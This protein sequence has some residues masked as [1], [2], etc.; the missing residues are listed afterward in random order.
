MNFNLTKKLLKLSCLFLLNLAIISCNNNDYNKLED[1][2]IEI[3]DEN[4]EALLIEQGID[5]DGIINQQILKS[6]A[7]KVITLDL[8]T[9]NNTIESIKGIEAFL[10]LKKLAAYGQDIKEVDLSNNKKLNTVYLQGNFLTTIDISNNKN[11]VF[12]DFSSNIITS[13]TGVSEA[14]KLKELQ[15]SYNLIEEFSMHNS[16]IEK[17]LM[18]GNLLTSF[19]ASGSANLNYL[20]LR[21]NLLTE[22]DLFQNTVLEHIIVDHNQIETINL[23]A[24]NN[25]K[26]LN[27]HTNNLSELNISMYPNIIKLTVNDNPNLSCVKSL[28]NQNIPTIIKSDYQELNEFCN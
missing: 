1:F 15:L 14:L 7:K 13:I 9:S 2:T 4:F 17:L 22:L 20:L 5:S 23:P 19:N 21:Q 26:Y 3:P 28:N 27:L 24:N 18:S 8:S 10:N 12:A 11:L 25:I 6:D 16:S